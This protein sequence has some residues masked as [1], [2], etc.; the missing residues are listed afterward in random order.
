[1]GIRDWLFGELKPRRHA[2]AAAPVNQPRTWPPASQT[3][4]PVARYKV[5]DLR[6]TWDRAVAGTGWF[7]ET[8]AGLPLGP[9]KVTLRLKPNEDN[10]YAVAAYVGNR[11]VGWLATDWSA[12]DPY[13]AWV[14]RLDAA[15]IRPRF[16]G[17][18]RLT[19]EV[20]KTKM[21]NFDMPEPKELTA[22]ADRLLSQFPNP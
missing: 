7:E 12:T 21:I 20:T 15:H 19:V 3:P 16:Q 1:M 4:K 14:T 5:V 17:E 11:Q 13:V 2:T 10:P 6:G 18:C 8:V 9:L 22:I